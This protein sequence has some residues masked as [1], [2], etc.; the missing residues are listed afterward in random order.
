MTYRNA[1]PINGQ[2][3]EWIYRYLDSAYPDNLTS[4]TDP[5]GVTTSYTYTSIGGGSLYPLLASQQVG[6]STNAR[7][8]FSY[9]T[10]VRCF[11]QPSAI[12]SALN[13]ELQRS[14]DSLDYDTN[15]NLSLTLSAIGKRT[16]Y[17]NDDIGRTTSSRTLI[18]SPSYGS[19]IVNPD[20]P[21]PPPPPPGGGGGGGT[22]PP[23]NSDKWI[24]DST[25]YDT[26][27]RAILSTTVAPEDL[28]RGI[29]EQRITVQTDY[30]GTSDLVARVYRSGNDAATVVDSMR[31]DALARMRS[32]WAQG[33]TVAE[34]LWYDA[35]SNVV[36]R[37]TPRGHDVTMQ[38]DALDRIS[39]RATPALSASIP[40]DTAW[41]S[42]DPLIGA[43]REAKNRDSRV[44]RGYTPNGWQNYELAEQRSETGT[45]VPAHSYVTQIEYDVAGRRT[46]LYHPWQATNGGTGYT[47]YTYS[48][49]DGGLQ[50]VTDP[51]NGTVTL[52][53]DLRGQLVVVTRPGNVEQRMEYT[54]DGELARDTISIPGALLR[55]T[56]F[57]YDL[58][59]K[60]ARSV[61]GSGPLD[62]LSVGYSP[63]GHVWS[64]VFSG[65]GTG[66]VGGTVT[67]GNTESY[68]HDALGNIL[69]GTFARAVG[70]NAQSNSSST[71]RNYSYDNTGRL[72]SMTDEWLT[73]YTYDAAGNLTL[74]AGSGVPS[75]TRA[76]TY[77]ATQQL[78]TSFTRTGQH[79]TSRI[80]TTTDTR[81]DA[82]G[83]RIWIKK[84]SQCSG[85]PEDTQ[86]F[87]RTSYVRR[88]AWDGDQEI[89]EFQGG[90][91]DS[92]TF[93]C[94]TP[95]PMQSGLPSEDE[96][97]LWGQ[98]LYVHGTSLDAPLA[99]VR[100]NYREYHYINSQWL[101][102]T[103]PTFALYPL[104][105]ARG[106]PDLA[107]SLTGKNTVCVTTDTPPCAQDFGWPAGM[108]PYMQQQWVKLSWLGSL[109]DDK[110][111]AGLASGLTYRRNRYVDGR[112]GRFSQPDP[113]GLVGG[114][115]TYTYGEGDP[116]NYRDPF[117][118]WPY[119][120]CRELT[121]PIARLSG[122]TH[123]ALRIQNDQVDVLI[124]L[125]PIGK[126]V[127]EIYWRSAAGEGASGAGESHYDPAGWSQVAAPD[128]MSE[129]DFD[130]AVLASALKMT[131]QTRGTTYDRDGSLNSNHFVFET[132]RRAGAK[133]PKAAVK[134]KGSPGLCGGSG[135][136]TGTNCTP[137][138]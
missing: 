93:A 55:S 29:V 47:T 31:Y 34:S 17:A 41:F 89:A 27:D 26:L 59:G 73:N 8:D 111:D 44:W 19:M 10:V 56:Q 45:Y 83:R 115:N 138:K 131:Q 32:R 95:R 25:I 66:L 70:D 106:E 129:E 43:L 135:T 71:Q 72:A 128:G 132:L 84:V 126:D 23:W 108:T 28:N 13:Q 16:Q 12:R 2:T 133:P 20:D 76:D 96:C 67:S 15:G 79:L 40:L 99:V 30:D 137:K 87:C 127:N 114:L 57:W 125:V 11:G 58:R 65:S 18:F 69:G 37:R 50:S 52:A 1:D 60:L 120:Q 130:K 94:G 7:V 24:V 21:P 88:T 92:G 53:R 14:R 107:T 61:N 63:M 39:W 103:F 113:V 100:S 35:A 33:F 117:G 3:P 116:A 101:L 81:Y 86:H 109:L 54:P 98:T 6:P 121:N 38:Y 36:R 77:N 118:L 102:R 42:Y 90:E 68:T 134:G 85:T 122:Y 48:P 49:T 22:Y 97:P 82:L 5:T 112:T 104:W 119:V 46:K 75:T 74:S 78:V 136:D 105:N 62:N 123:C 64:S 4:T 91:E 51:M 9:C 110:R 80:Q 124:E